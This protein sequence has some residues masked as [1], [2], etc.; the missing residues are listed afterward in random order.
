MHVA[1]MCVG[2]LHF[3]R[4]FTWVLDEAEV[5]LLSQLGVADSLSVCSTSRS[6]ACLLQRETER[7]RVDQ[8]D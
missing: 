6:V 4:V 2:C 3:V 7:S 1:A 5:A 8:T